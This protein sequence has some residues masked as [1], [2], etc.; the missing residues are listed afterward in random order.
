MAGG[1]KNTGSVS[2]DDLI[3]ALIEAFKSDAVMSLITNIVEKAVTGVETRLFALEEEVVSCNKKIADQAE[4]IAAQ[5][6]QIVALQGSVHFQEQYSRRNNLRVYNSWTEQKD[7]NT[8]TLII[9]MAQDIGVNLAETD[10]DCSHRIGQFTAGKSRPIIVKL[11][12]HNKRMELIRARRKLAGRPISIA[13]DLTSVNAKIAAY[14]RELK[15]EGKIIDTWTWEG[16]VIIK[17]NDRTKKTVKNISS[18]NRLA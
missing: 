14:A 11:A 8:D 7:E 18:L 15:R 9:S 10:I 5:G 13:D 12:T 16:S 1:K 2:G 6:E 3:T 4:I 17:Q